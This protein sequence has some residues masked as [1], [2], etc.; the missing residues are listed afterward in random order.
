VNDYVTVE[1]AYHESKEK[2]TDYVESKLFEKIDEGNLTAIIFYLK[3]Q[4][5][6]RGYGQGIEITG[7][8]G[9]PIE[10]SYVNDWRNA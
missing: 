2:K 7:K 3:T 10:I 1:Q 4:G 9:D 5:R 8:G 6:D